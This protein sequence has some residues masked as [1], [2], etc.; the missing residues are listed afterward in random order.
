M[1]LYGTIFDMSEIRP[2]LHQVVPTD[3]GLNISITGASIQDL[4]NLLSE[5]FIMRGFT[6]G[7]GTPIAGTYE[8]GSKGARVALGGLVKRQKYSVSIWGDNNFVNAIVQSEMSGASGSVLGVVRERKGRDEI[9]TALQ[10]FLQS[11]IS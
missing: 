11:R 1:K 4:A 2:L 7:T 10:Y 6:L 3:K 5:F 8:T 9:K